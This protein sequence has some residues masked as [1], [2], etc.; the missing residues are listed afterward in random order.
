M[1]NQNLF[2]H[3]AEIIRN[4]DLDKIKDVATLPTSM[5]MA[6]DGNLSIQYIPFDYV[7]PEARLV[8][9]GITP[10]FTQLQNALHEAQKQLHAGSDLSTA[11]IAAKNTGAFSGSMRP[12]LVSMLDHLKINEWLN[13]ATCD[14][15]FG[16]DS[17]L[18]QTT[19]VL[20]YP[21]FVNGENYNGTPNM[22]KH[23]L[24]QKQL[25]DHFAKEC[26]LL[27]NAIIVPLGPKVSEGLDFLVKQG[28]VDERNVLEGMPHPSGANAERIAY[29]LG[30]KNRDQ[31]SVKTD[32]AKLDK[33]KTLLKAKIAALTKQ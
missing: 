27:K 12:N 1:K 7:N 22:T 29:F 4:M 9:V 10:G 24:L 33:A 18:V 17:H 3:F 5:E 30:K 11:L 15:L 21:V 16:K 13:I 19:S 32:P 23:P 31:L 6:R 28:L 2:S 20:R 8:I 25:K 26:N 14:T